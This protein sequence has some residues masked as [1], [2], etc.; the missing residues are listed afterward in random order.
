MQNKNVKNNN[1][2][3]KYCV[4]LAGRKFGEFGESSLICQTET[5]S[6]YTVGT[7]W[8]PQKIVKI[9]AYALSMLW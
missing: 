9:I 5:I 2:T 3:E 8:N 1:M 4:S 7:F 6:C